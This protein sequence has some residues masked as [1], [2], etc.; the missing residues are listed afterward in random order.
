M[1]ELLKKEFF[2]ELGDTVGALR[3]LS[4]PSKGQA[5]GHYLRSY[6]Q[7][8]DILKPVLGDMLRWDATLNGREVLR[9]LLTEHQRFM[10][11]EINYA[12]KKTLMKIKNERMRKKKEQ[13]SVELSFNYIKITPL[14]ADDMYISWEEEL[15]RNRERVEQEQNGDDPIVKFVSREKLIRDHFIDLGDEM[16]DLRSNPQVLL[17]M[18]FKIYTK[19]LIFNSKQRNIQKKIIKVINGFYDKVAG[20]QYALIFNIEHKKS[21]TIAVFNALTVPLRASGASTLQ[22]FNK[23]G[24]LMVDNIDEG[25]GTCVIDFIFN[26]Y[27][28]KYSRKY[29]GNGKFP[30]MTKDQI[31]DDITSGWINTNRQS[32]NTLLKD[33]APPN[34]EEYDANKDGVCILQLE[35]FCY[36]NKITLQCLDTEFNIFHTKVYKNASRESMMVIISD[37]HIYNIKDK[38]LRKTVQNSGRGA[39][40]MAIL[41]KEQVPVRELEDTVARTEINY[42]D[43]SDIQERNIFITGEKDLEDLYIQLWAKENSKY[44]YKNNCNLMTQILLKDKTIFYNP[45]YEAVLDICKN[46]NINFDNQSLISIGL[47]LYQKVNPDFQ[48]SNFYSYFNT[49]TSQFFQSARRDNWVTSYKEG[50]EYD[51]KDVS[52]VDICKCYSSILGSDIDWMCF[53]S[54]DEVKTYTGGHILQN[55]FYYIATNATVLFQGTGVYMGELVQIGLEDGIITSEDIKFYIS[56]KKTTKGKFKPFVDYVFENCGENAKY[57]INTFIGSA[58]G[59]TLKNVGKIRYTDN[60]NTASTAFFRKDDDPSGREQVVNVFVKGVSED[61]TKKLYGIDNTKREALTDHRYILHVQIIQK[62]YIKVYNMCKANGINIAEDLIAVKTDNIVFKGEIK[63]EIG[64]EIGDYRQE[65]LTRGVLS[66]LKNNTHNKLEFSKTKTFQKMEKK[67]NDIEIED[68]YNIDE[69]VEKTKD[70]DVLLMGRAGT[71]KSYVLRGIYQKL[72]DEGKNVVCSAFT[73]KAKKHLTD[74]MTLHKMFGFD[75]NGKRS[76]KTNFNKVDVVIVDE[77]SMMS[78]MFYDALI[79][80]KRTNP[81]IRFIL[82]G[83]FNQLQPVGEEHITFL[84]L[85][86]IYDLCPNKLILKVNKRVQDNGQ[87]FYELMEKALNGEEFTL[88]TTEAPLDL[89]L[90][91]TNKTRKIINRKLMLKKRGHNFKTMVRNPEHN[92]VNLKLKTYGNSQTMYLYEGLPLLCKGGRD[93]D[94]LTNGDLLTVESFTD[95]EVVMT[96]TDN[97]IFA[98]KLNDMFIYTFYPAYCL[99]IHSAQ[100]DTIDRPYAIYDMERFPSVNMTYTALSRST[101][102]YNIFRGSLINPKQS[103]T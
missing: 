63:C 74:G 23:D 46:L 8:Y 16:Y 88:P 33:C 89:N 1:N 86:V 30:Y 76:H 5:R 15:K 78:T 47:D 55:A 71:G 59:K 11:A 14:T 52:S 61:G 68:E 4:V 101:K 96:R 31:A 97:T 77:V 92:R 81:K 53:S 54:L 28:K 12:P 60:L 34:F 40:H 64:E 79:S 85:R 58:L 27:V 99:T 13:V 98:I 83:D 48:L 10:R 69:I 93:L 67:F 87:E 103:F 7:G 37:G 73:H 90:C 36:T 25:S 56:T 43:I 20:V 84:N 2:G 35:D 80:L 44:A 6:K 45:D 3:D 94:D 82:C 39:V 9:Q 72:K 65:T 91:Y 21:K 32:P 51:L 95:T 17:D 18:K 49:E 22:L 75:I 66:K 102:L 19:K 26:N 38:T 29:G 57:I 24:E 42:E 62:T 41:E 50:K 100:G 70:K